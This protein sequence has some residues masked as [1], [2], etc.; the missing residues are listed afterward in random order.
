MGRAKATQL[1]CTIRTVQGQQDK[2]TLHWQ[3]MSQQGFDLLLGEYWHVRC[4]AFNILI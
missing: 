3:R 2:S 1:V 4:F